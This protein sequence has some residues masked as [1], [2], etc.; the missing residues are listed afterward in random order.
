MT[1]N[2][3]LACYVASGLA[4][5]LMGTATDIDLA[6]ARAVFDPRSGVFPLRHAWMTEVLGH[7]VLKH[8]MTAAGAALVIA[9][10]VDRYRPFTALPP[11]VRVRLRVIAFSAV[12]VPLVVMLLKR[13]SSSHCPWDLLEFSGTQAYVR[14]FDTD[15]PGTLPGHCMPAGHASSA[16]WLVSLAVIWLPHRPRLAILAGGGGLGLGML[17]GGVQQLRGA[18]FLTHTLWTA[19]IACAV[20]GL[21]YALLVIGAVRRGSTTT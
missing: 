14:L 5:L 9:V 7:T 11:D 4:I 12:L 8:L 21:L 20:A 2:A 18:H 10:A 3:I 6:L 16:M 19:W 15:V 17:L 1:R 13:A